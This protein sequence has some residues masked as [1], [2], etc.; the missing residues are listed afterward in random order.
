MPTS[1]ASSADRSRRPRGHRRPPPL[2]P[3]ASRRGTPTQPA[4]RSAPEQG[5]RPGDP[6]AV[7]V[8]PSGV[9]G[10]PSAASG[11]TSTPA[12]RATSPV[13]PVQVVDQPRLAPSEPFPLVVRQR[14]QSV[15]EDAPP[16]HVHHGAGIDAAAGTPGEADAPLEQ[17]GLRRMEPVPVRADGCPA[18][19]TDPPV[20]DGDRLPG[21][22]VAPRRPAAG[23]SSHRHAAHSSPRQ[24]LGALL[25][26]VAALTPPRT[27]P[28]RQAAARPRRRRPAHGSAA[29]GP[30][31]GTGRGPG[32]G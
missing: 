13:L 28:P 16:R 3:R 25:R 30:G 7:P 12:R 29:A 5:N 21:P 18:G 2:L 11:S 31:P 14:R 8:S 32:R 15:D 1:P 23:C 20:T 6:G 26:P 4:R 22:D 24:A 17:R 19:R 10:S 9:E 27:T